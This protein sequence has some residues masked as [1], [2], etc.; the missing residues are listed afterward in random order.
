MCTTQF[1][2]MLAVLGGL[3]DYVCGAG[4]GSWFLIACS[5]D[6]DREGKM[7]TG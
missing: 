2:Q 1:F 6:E 5:L 3:L 7:K 4:D